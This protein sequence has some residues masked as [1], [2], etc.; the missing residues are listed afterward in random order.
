MPDDQTSP[1]PVIQDL[2]VPDQSSS[3]SG[4]Q[5][6]LDVVA[7]DSKVLD[8]PSWL[9]KLSRCYIKCAWNSR[10]HEDTCDTAGSVWLEE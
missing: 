5:A 6:S 3:V 9:Y 10:W 7:L 2:V 1:D 8:D 4:G